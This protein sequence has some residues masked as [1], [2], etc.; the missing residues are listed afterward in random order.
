MGKSWKSTKWWLIKSW[1]NKFWKIKATSH[2]ANKE[3]MEDLSI[4]IWVIFRICQVGK[5]TRPVR[6]DLNQIPYEYTEK[7]TNR[8]K[9]L[10]LGNTAPKELWTEVHNTIQ[11][12]MCCSPR[13]CKESDT[14]WPLN[15]SKLSNEYNAVQENGN[16]KLCL[17]RKGRKRSNLIYTSLQ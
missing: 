15:N 12:T 9:G 10:G 4:L 6:Y 7:V 14:P 2:P 1:W 13:G 16:C 5:T 11:E 3:I 8:F 17:I